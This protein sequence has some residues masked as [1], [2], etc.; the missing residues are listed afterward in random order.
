MFFSNRVSSM[1]LLSAFIVGTINGSLLVY[2]IMNK[3][4]TK[5]FRIYK[6]NIHDKYVS[7]LRSID[8]YCCCGS[9]KKVREVFEYGY[10]KYKENNNRIIQ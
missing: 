2:L 3:K 6:N 7:Y 5:T 10:D 4:F 8:D 1:M 9:V